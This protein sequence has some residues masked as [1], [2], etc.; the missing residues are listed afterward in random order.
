[1][2][3][4]ASGVPERPGTEDCRPEERVYVGVV[5]EH[6]V[7]VPC[8]AL[9]PLEAVMPRARRCLC[10]GKPSHTGPPRACRACLT[11]Q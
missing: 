6:A 5:A 8:L 7:P 1:M 10:W 4:D 3:D 2:V 9:A 11:V